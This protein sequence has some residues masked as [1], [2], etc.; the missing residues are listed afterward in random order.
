M[1]DKDLLLKI[2]LVA[3]EFVLVILLSAAHIEIVFDN[4][5]REFVH[6][7]DRLMVVILILLCLSDEPYS[8]GAQ[9]LHEY[10]GWIKR[11]PEFF[12][13]LVD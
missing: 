4:S 2:R 8:C 13:F 3:V 12:D 7:I 11:T 9:C 5:D 1:V 6:V 10:L